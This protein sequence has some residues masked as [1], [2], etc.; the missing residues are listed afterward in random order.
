LQ[1]RTNTVVGPSASISL[2]LVV[3]ILSGLCL[4][5]AVLQYDWTGEISRVE[6]ER[7]EASVAEGLRAVAL[8]FDSA[9]SRSCRSLRPN[10]EN[11]AAIGFEEANAEVIQLWKSSQPEPIFKR[12]AYAVEERGEVTLYM[13]RQE[14]GELAISDWPSEW[15]DLRQALRTMPHGQGRPFGPPR[16]GGARG[17]W[18]PQ[19]VPTPLGD[20]S[21]L[22]I[23]FP[24]FGAEMRPQRRMGPDGDPLE[25]NQPRERQETNSGARFAGKREWALLELDADFLRERWMPRLLGQ[26][27]SEP[28]LRLL[29]WLEI[30]PLYSKGKPIYTLGRKES[31]K[32]EKPIT[33]SFNQMGTSFAPPEL[34]RIAAWSIEATLSKTQLAMLVARERWWNL[35]VALVLNLALLM[36]AVI[37]VRCARQSQA[38]ATARMSLVTNVSHE[39]RTPITVIRAAAHNLMKGVIEDP[40]KVREYAALIVEHSEQLSQMVEQVLELGSATARRPEGAQ[41]RVDVTKAV[42]DAIAETAEATEGLTMEVQM[43]PGLS[44][45]GGDASALRRVF[46]NLIANA[47]KHGGRGKWIGIT[48]VLDDESEPEMVEVQVA[49]RGDGIPE[50]ELRELFKP[51]FRGA[52]AKAEHIRGSG[53]GLALAKEIVEAHNGTISAE[54]QEGKGASFTV[55]LPTRHG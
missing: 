25:A 16:F 52:R 26:Y 37:L 47:A 46:Q 31:G 1:R 11:I 49:D 13:V 4:V 35:G 7:L 36:A 12:I 40:A 44:A 50:G 10:P 54:S 20:P 3:V 21:G 14:D 34:Q 33:V 43:A 23:Q 8:A 2:G 18:Q 53:L 17:G 27:I 24:V 55:R 22:L 28:N 48:G 51:F 19:V 15:S 29:E 5:L 41:Q 45:A 9:L 39:L 42:M 32:N 38:L 6:T 30:R